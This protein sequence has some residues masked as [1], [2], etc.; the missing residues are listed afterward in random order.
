[1]EITPMVSMRWRR[2]P[3]RR[4]DTERAQTSASQ[5]V[6]CAQH[7]SAVEWICAGSSECARSNS[8]H[9]SKLLLRSRWKLSLDIDRHGRSHSSP[10]ASATRSIVIQKLVPRTLHLVCQHKKSSKILAQRNVHQR[11]ANATR[12]VM[13]KRATAQRSET[14]SR[15]DRSRAARPAAKVLPPSSCIDGRHSA[16]RGSYQPRQRGAIPPDLSGLALHGG[17]VGTSF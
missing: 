16:D 11:A 7:A 13:E 2:C 6:H 3:P 17:W 1:M 4:T 12:R 8:T 5:L 10:V 9:T 14:R 15:V